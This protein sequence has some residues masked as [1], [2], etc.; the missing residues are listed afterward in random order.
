MKTTFIRRAAWLSFFFVGAC[1]FSSIELDKVQGPTF[2]NTFALNLGSIQ[3]SASELVETIEDETLQVQEGDDFSLTFIHQDTSFF[4]DIADFIV[5]EEDISNSDTYTP[6]DVS[7]P[8]QGSENVVVLPTETFDFEFNSDGDEKIDS[9]F[10]KGGRLEY[11]LSSPFNVQI[12]YVFTLIDVLDDSNNPV[13]FTNTLTESETSKTESISLRGLKNVAERVGDAN[14]FNVS[15]DMTFTIPAGRA[16][17]AA[18]EMS[19]ELSFRNPEFSAIFGDF[20]SEPVDVQEDTTTFDS[21][22]EFNDGGLFLRNPSITMDFVNLFGIELG[23]SLDGVKSVDGSGVERELSGSVVDDLQFVD[24]PNDTQI[25]TAV[26][27]SFSIDISNSNIDEL[28]NNTPENLIFSVTATPN[29]VGSDNLNNYLFDSSYIEIR[30]RVEIPLDF[31]MDGFSKDFDLDLSGN[32]I[33]GADSL[34]INARVVNELPLN[35]SLD[36]SFRDAN[37]NELYQIAAIDLIESPS[38]GSDGRAVDASESNASVRLDDEG[39]AA[40]LDAEEI[41]AT[42]N[43]FT[44]DSENGT[45]VQIFSDYNLEIF[46]TAEGTVEVEL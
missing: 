35:G 30:T 2:K 25:G 24:A 39:I 32:D 23:V 19:I 40:F 22:D 12:D 44:F 16:I 33:D 11:T 18:E 37:G 28:L 27:S 46:L 14:I 17:N 7:I 13:R 43:V 21:F 42:V 38:I 9:T 3:Y 41:I 29:P 15:L 31:R 34:I 45:F 8:A 20:G 6:F 10:F 26:N 36:L 1:D 5:L 4:D